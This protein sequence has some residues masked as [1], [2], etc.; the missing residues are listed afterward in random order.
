MPSLVRLREHSDNGLSVN[1]LPSK[2]IEYSEVSAEH[3][4]KEA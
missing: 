3:R 2:A 1:E 4:V